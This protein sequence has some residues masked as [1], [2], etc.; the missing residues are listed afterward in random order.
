M[1]LVS[2]LLHLQMEPTV[3]QRFTIWF[4]LLSFFTPSDSNIIKHALKLSSTVSTSQVTT[5]E[6]S[7]S[8][9]QSP[10]SNSGFHNH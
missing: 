2:Q 1:I 6:S 5:K 8:E 3:R 10:V 7:D 9:I 4:Y